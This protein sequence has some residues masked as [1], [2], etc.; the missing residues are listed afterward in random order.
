MADTKIIDAIL[1]LKPTAQVVITGTN[2]DTCEIDWHDGTTDISR[3]N[4]KT[5]MEND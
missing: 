3:A 4:I 2:I 5:E 1:R